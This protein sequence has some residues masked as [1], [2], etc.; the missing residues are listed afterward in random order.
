MTTA[1]IAGP[2]TGD[3]LYQRRARKALP[4]LVRQAYA[5]QPIT[6]SDL[7]FELSMPN[8]RN[9]NYVL[10]SIGQT[11]ENI[12]EEWEYRVPPIQC[13]VINKA[14]R[15]PGEGVSEFISE[16]DEFRSMPLWKR[17]K[18]VETKQNEVFVY[19]Y[20]SD[21][22]EELELEEN[23]DNFEATI[24]NA[25]RRGGGESPDHLKLKEYVARNP[26]IVGLPAT[27]GVGKTEYWLPS[28]D[29]LDVFF[30]KGTMH[31]GVEVK[32]ARSDQN[33]IV[34]GL[35]QCVK[36]LAV[37]EARQ[38]AKGHPQNAS[39]LLV[40]EGGLPDELVPLKNIL[41]VQVLENITP[42]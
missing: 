32:S 19:E 25:S 40:L 8:P 15:L 11:L 5:W 18:L 1:Q 30:K 42:H 10:G 7:A 29:S 24:D 34:R 4:I 17:R 33:D 22:L 21:V 3:K 38:A 27:V 6:Y 16:L 37:L 28:G 2:I 20:W 36:Y 39:S 41:G 31:I 14:T 23:R 35:F 12:A 13:L 9:L 26:K